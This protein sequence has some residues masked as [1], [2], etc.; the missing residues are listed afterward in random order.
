MANDNLLDPPPSSLV[1]A[2]LAPIRPAELLPSH[3]FDA[4]LLALYAE[5]SLPRGELA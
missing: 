5:W 1:V 3:E 2:D 4:T